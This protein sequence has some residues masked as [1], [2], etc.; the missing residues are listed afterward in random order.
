MVVAIER[1][2]TSTKEW[3]MVCCFLVFHEMG[4]LPRINQP[5][6]DF[7]VKGQSAQSDSHQA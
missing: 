5:V 3:D 7:M 1:Y 6:R 4:E 2:S